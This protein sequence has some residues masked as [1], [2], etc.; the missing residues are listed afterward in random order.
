MLLI[1]SATYARWYVDD[2]R[3]TEKRAKQLA[4]FAL[5]RL[6]TQASLHLSDP[7][8]IPEAYISMGQLRDDVLRDE[9]SSRR[10]QNLWD[11]V[12]RKVE[13]NSNVR[14]NVRESRSGEVSRVWEWVGAVK[15][16]EDRRS[17]GAWSQS[18]QSFGDGEGNSEIASSPLKGKSEVESQKWDEGRPIY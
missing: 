14:P 16:L 9:F 7:D 1:G 8:H 3:A 12:Q 5:D 15:Q 10:R 13:H 11:K 4:S 2:S 18:R 6:A 17:S